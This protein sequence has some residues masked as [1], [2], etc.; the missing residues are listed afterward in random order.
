MKFFMKKGMNMH[1]RVMHSKSVN[2][3][4][5]TK[6]IPMFERIQEAITLWKNNNM[7][8]YFLLSGEAYFAARCWANTHKTYKSDSETYSEEIENYLKTSEQLLGG[9]AG[10]WDMLEERAN[11]HDCG[12]SWK[13]SNIKYC[14]K[15]MNFVCLRCETTH[16]SACQ[17]RIVG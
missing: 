6:Q 16:Y 13:K 10:W 12:E 17:E 5:F 14:V 8:K 11:C 3:I 4:L 15:C 2:E 7:H 1:N 9:D